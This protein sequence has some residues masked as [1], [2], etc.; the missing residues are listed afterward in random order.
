MCVAPRK[1][2]ER[3]VA[4]YER[5]FVKYFKHVVTSPLRK[6]DHPE[7][8]TSDLLDDVGVRNYQSLIGGL[9]WCISIRRFD[10]ATAVMSMSGFKVA[11]RV[12]TWTA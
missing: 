9:Q 2:I 4:N 7:L 8:D 6:G 11:P 3:I 5:I 10:V 12:D 1:Y